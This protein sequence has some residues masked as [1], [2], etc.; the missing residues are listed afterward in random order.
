MSPLKLD[1]AA[2]SSAIATALQTQVGEVLHRRG[3]VEGMSGGIDSSVYA[4]LAVRA[5]GAERVVRSVH[6]GAGLGPGQSGAGAR[7]RGAAR[8]RAYDASDHARAEGAGC[9]RPD[10]PSFFGEHAPAYVADALSPDGHG[11]S[12][13][14]EPRPVAGLRRRCQANRVTGFRENQAFVAI[15]ST[16]LCHE[17][18]FGAKRP[19][20]SL[21]LDRADVLALEAAPVDGERVTA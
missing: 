14:F 19:S 20:L 6:A 1:P 16:Q 7:L 15:L 8:D 9:Y 3:L 4:G 11:A 18:F 10:V 5:L 21:P 13:L 12:G 2:A 17:E